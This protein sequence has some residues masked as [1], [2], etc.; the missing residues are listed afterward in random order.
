ML[1]F[2]STKMLDCLKLFHLVIRFIPST[3]FYYSQYSILN[4]L[5]TF[6][7]LFQLA[8]WWGA[9]WTHLKKIKVNELFLMCNHY[10]KFFKWRDY[11][12]QIGL[13]YSFNRIFSPSEMW[14]DKSLLQCSVSISVT[15]VFQCHCLFFSPAHSYC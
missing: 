3:L 14:N 2:F 9:V 11:R 13:W 6:L 4:S 8:L 7:L 1:Y 5:T 10:M 15:D 12:Y